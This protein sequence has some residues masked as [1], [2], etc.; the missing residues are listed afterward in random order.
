M[1]YVGTSGW[2]YRHWRERFYPKGLAQTRWLPYYAE[3][4]QTVE[5]NNTFYNLPRGETFEK[6]AR[7][8][9][10]DFIF[11]LKVSRF[12]TQ[13]K[14]LKD[15]EEP[16]ER[17]MKAASRLGDKIGPLLLQLPPDFKADPE[18]LRHAL[19]AFPKGL[20]VAVEFRHDSWFTDQVRGVLEDTNAALCLADRGGKLITADWRTADWGYVRLHWGSASP[21]SCYTERELETWAQR[22]R[23]VYR[24]RDD[25]YVFFNN[26]PNACAL[27]DAQVLAALFNDEKE[28][29]VTR[30]PEEADVKVG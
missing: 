18:R 4:F 30:V 26:D 15:P 20:R 27:R 21:E 23:D 5:V 11:A 24:A 7:E 28:W 10:E 3:R 14:R 9:P 22:L 25:V 19:R 12:L 17:F 13:F 2:Q 16:V 29:R 1:I 6:W 8:T